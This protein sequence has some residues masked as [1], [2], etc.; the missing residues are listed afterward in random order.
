MQVL[1][2]LNLAL[3]LLCSIECLYIVKI[4]T[5]ERFK[6]DRKKRYLSIT[7]LLLSWRVIL[8]AIS[9]Y[10]LK[11]GHDILAVVGVLDIP[12]SS[13]ILNAIFLA[14]LAW[15]LRKYYFELKWTILIPPIVKHKTR[16]R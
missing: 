13:E 15:G 6:S 2:T 11:V 4:L 8:V 14:L 7:G 10:A 9:I 1:T 16:R 12:Y 3:A 5:D